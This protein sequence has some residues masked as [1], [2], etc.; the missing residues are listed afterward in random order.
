[1]H[2][3]QNANKVWLRHWLE[4]LLVGVGLWL[5]RSVHLRSV[6]LESLEESQAFV[7]HGIKGRLDPL[8]FHLFLIVQVLQIIAPNFYVIIDTIYYAL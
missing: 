8:Y 2:R 4:G 5:K 6:G 3:L 1:M 7:E